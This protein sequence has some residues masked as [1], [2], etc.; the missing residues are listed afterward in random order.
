MTLKPMLKRRFTEEQ[1]KQIRNEFYRD[2]LP[3]EAILAKWRISRV[4]LQ[5]VTLCASVNKRG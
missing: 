2:K 5:R 1:E 3:L 4:V